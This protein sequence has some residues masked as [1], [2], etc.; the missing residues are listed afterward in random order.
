MF[1]PRLQCFEP[2][3]SQTHTTLRCA[4]PRRVSQTLHAG[5]RKS[6]AP[7]RY[8]VGPR[9]QPL[10]EQILNFPIAAAQDDFRPFDELTRFGS[11]TADPFELS[12]LRVAR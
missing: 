12:P 5:A 6:A 7:L 1:K 2:F 8:G 4:R 3:L 10:G 9:S 11:A